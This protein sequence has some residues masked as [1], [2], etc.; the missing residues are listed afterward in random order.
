[1]HKFIPL[2]RSTSIGFR[3]DVLDV[4][5]NVVV[6]DVA[7]FGADW[8]SLTLKETKNKQVKEQI[9]FLTDIFMVLF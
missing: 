8:T 5:F 7:G 9:I 4:V 1:M 3:V 2:W 6:L